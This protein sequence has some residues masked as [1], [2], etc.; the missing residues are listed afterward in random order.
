MSLPENDRD[1]ERWRRAHSW[2]GR[3][4][5]NDEQVLFARPGRVTLVQPQRIH[6]LRC[7]IDRHI[8]LVEHGGDG[9]E[10]GIRLACR[11]ADSASLVQTD[12]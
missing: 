4:Y 2:R 8:D 5:R 11:G 10:S 7:A 1:G 3:R 12:S 6:A 9:A